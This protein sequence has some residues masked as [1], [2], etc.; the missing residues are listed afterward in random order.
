M[1]FSNENFRAPGDDLS[2]KSENKGEIFGEKI[3]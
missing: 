3:H 2:I 1:N